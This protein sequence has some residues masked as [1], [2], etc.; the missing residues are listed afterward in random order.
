MSCPGSITTLT[1]SIVMAVSAILEVNMNL[2]FPVSSN[3]FFCSEGVIFP[4]SG[5][6]SKIFLFKILL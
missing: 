1:P 2:C 5:K 6:T 4:W 3:T